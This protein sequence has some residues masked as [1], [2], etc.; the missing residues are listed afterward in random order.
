M[1]RLS[2]AVHIEGLPCLSPQYGNS[3]RQKKELFELEA[4]KVL[5]L[6]SLGIAAL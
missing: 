3:I 5:S 2:S 6:L 4:S 1:E